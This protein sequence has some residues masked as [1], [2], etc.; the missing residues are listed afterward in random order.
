MGRALRSRSGRE[1]VFREGLVTGPRIRPFGVLAVLI[2]LSLVLAAC[3]SSDKPD[4][5][6]TTTTVFSGEVPQGGKIVVGAEQE[7][8]CFDWVGQCGGSSWGT[9]MAQI[10]T[11]PQVFR[12]I[13]EGGKFVETPGPVL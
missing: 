4:A 1:L 11:L 6:G 10:Q 5:G 2:V 8:D 13:P 3:G 9:W 7:P 12:I